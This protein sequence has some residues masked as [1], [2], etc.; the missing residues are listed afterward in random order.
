MIC[1]LYLSLWLIKTAT[2]EAKVATLE[3]ENTD[4]RADI[5]LIKEHLGI[6]TEVG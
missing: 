3:A 6:S 5:E 4:L 1:R 2:L